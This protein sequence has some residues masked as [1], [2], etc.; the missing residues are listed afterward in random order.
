V[1]L[2]SAFCRALGKDAFA[3]CRPQ[4]SP[5]LGNDHV[6]REQDSQ[7]RNTLSKE[8]FAERQTLGEGGARQRAR[9]QPSIASLSSAVAL[10]TGIASLPSAM[11][12]TLGKEAQQRT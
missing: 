4:Q 1:A 2:P 9:Q 6:C 11:A 10:G 8:I 5:A 3:E 12:L 7:H